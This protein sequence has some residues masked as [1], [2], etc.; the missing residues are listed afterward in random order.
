LINY[1]VNVLKILQVNKFY[2]QRGG[3]E[4]CLFTLESLLKEAGHE[5]AI[6]S[7]KHPENLPSKYERY[8]VEEVDYSDPKK[9]SFAEKCRIALKL[10]YS[11]E[12]KRKISQLIA[13][14]KPDIIHYHNIYHQLSPSVLG[15]RQG[16]GI[17]TVLT[18]HDYKLACPNEQLFSN[19]AVCEKCIKGRY[20]YA[21]LRRCIKDSLPMSALGAIEATMHAL[22]N[23][24]RKNMDVIV[25]PSVFLA[26]I[27]K[28]SGYSKARIEIIPNAVDVPNFSDTQEKRDYCLYIGR[29]ARSKGILTL[30]KAIKK[31]ENTKLQI[32]GRGEDE[33]IKNFIE[34]HYL[35]H[36]AWRGFQTGKKLFDI[37]RNC[38]F[39]VLPSEGYENCPMSVLEAFAYGKPVIGSRIGGIPEQI[40]HGYNGY[41][42]EPGNVQQLSKLIGKC[43]SD[44]EH[45]I[46]MGKNAWRIFEEKYSPQVYLKKHLDLYNEI[47]EAQRLKQS[48]L[49]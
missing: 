4:R 19:D 48:N 45:T 44:K 31:L 9:Y 8:F 40:T 1:L 6:F 47:V 43:F 18:V 14:F 37:V 39:L 10:I 21:V 25:S 49:S 16:R 36:V 22:C 15:S 28:R 5:V 17:P 3:A 32:V 42:F 35:S 38:L 27:I 12:A 34:K 2:Y 26:N 20:Y 13:D 33:S 29:I 7:M 23:T 41:L 30:L 46:Q 24:Y 11:S